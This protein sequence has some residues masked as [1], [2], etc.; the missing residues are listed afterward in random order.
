MFLPMANIIQFVSILQNWIKNTKMLEII[1]KVL[2]LIVKIH[3]VS[4]SSNHLLLKEVE[5]LYFEISFRISKLKFIVGI[6]IA[7]VFTFLEY[8]T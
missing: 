7:A 6:N 3:Y 8:S 2:S 4:I 5:N 1:S